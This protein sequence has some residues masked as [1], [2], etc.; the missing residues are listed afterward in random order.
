MHEPLTVW[1]I[2]EGFAGSA[3]VFII[4]FDVF[5]SVVVPRPVRSGLRISAYLLRGTWRS[6][7]RIGL[8]LE[9]PQRRDAFLGV[10]ASLAVVLLLI[11]WEGGLILGFGLFFHGMRHDVRPELH[12]YGQAL[13]FAATSLLTIG[14]GDF[15]PIGGLTR[16]VAVIAGA[17]GLAT[18]A[19]VLTFLFALFGSFQRRELFVVMLDA[20]SGAPA[21]GL[22]LLETHAQL[23]LVDDLPRLFQ[24]GQTWAAEVLD[25]H[26]AYPILAYFRSSHVDVSW[27]SALGAVLDAATL[28][29]STLEAVPK[30]HAIL[31]HSVGSH[32]THDLSNYF[33]FHSNTDVGVEPAEYA[34]ARQR[35]LAAGFRLVPE[36]EGW[37]AFQ[38]L[39]S[40]YASAL[41]AMARYWA[42]TPAQWIGDRS[43]ISSRHD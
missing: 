21:S 5:T 38:R 14:F 40:E 36:A 31:M 12:N 7:R 32:L 30:G 34:Q 4:L 1:Q 17:S 33:R 39:R 2:F 19:L 24:Q 20:R 26:L 16:L 13:Y 23:Q 8:R 18:I 41:N 3:L 6:W 22:A 28:L 35:L 42:I 9:P 37:T 11:V 25:N 43:P 29:I 15:V 27:L 10:F